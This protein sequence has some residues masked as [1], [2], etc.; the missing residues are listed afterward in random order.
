MAHKSRT[1]AVS[2]SQ[3]IVLTVL[4]PF[5]LPFR[6][7]HHTIGRLFRITLMAAGAMAPIINGSMARAAS[8]EGLGNLG[9]RWSVAQAVSADGTVVVGDSEG[10]S[11]SEAFRWENGSMIGLGLLVPEGMTGLSSATGVS[12]D[13]SVVVGYATTE[14]TDFVGF[15]WEDSMEPLP[16]SARFSSWYDVSA[17]GSVIVGAADTGAEAARWVNGAMEPLGAGNNSHARAVSSDGSVVVGRSRFTPG[18]EAF[19]WENG[20]MIGLD[21]VYGASSLPRDVSADGSVVVGSAVG[22]A[23]RWEDGVME[24]LGNQPSGIFSTATGVSADGSVLVGQGSFDNVR[25]AVIWDADRGMRRIKDVLVNDFGLDLTGWTLSEVYDVSADGNVIVGAGQ[26]PQGNLEG[27]IAR[28][29]VGE[30]FHWASTTSGNYSVASNWTPEG[31]PGETDNAIFDPTGTYTVTIDDD[32]P[33]GINSAKVEAGQVTFEFDGDALGMDTLTV[34]GEGNSA[35]LKLFGTD[36][37]IVTTS[38]ATGGGSSLEGPLAGQVASQNVFVL[39]QGV[40]EVFSDANAIMNL[41]VDDKAVVEGLLEIKE[42]GRLASSRLIIGD[43]G[44][45]GSVKLSSTVVDC[46]ATISAANAVLGDDQNFGIVAGGKGTLEIGANAEAV[47][48][49]LIVGDGGEGQVTVKDGGRLDVLGEMILADNVGAMGQVDVEGNSQVTVGG[50]ITVGS[51]VNAALAFDLD[52][53]L[54]IFDTAQVNAATGLDVGIYGLV[55]IQGRDANANATLVLSGDLFVR[56]DA[57][58]VVL[59]DGGRLE[60]P[61]N[62]HVGIKLG[63]DSQLILVSP[64]AITDRPSAVNLAESSTLNIEIGLP[65]DSGV[66][67]K[68]EVYEGSILNASLIE[69]GTA[70]LS[71]GELIVDTRNTGRHAQVRAQIIDVGANGQ[72]L[73]RNGATV[74]LGNRSS[75]LGAITTPPN[76][77]A[78]K[79]LVLP[80]GF[81]VFAGM[82]EV[83]DALVVREGGYV[84]TGSSPGQG[85]LS[86][87]FILEEGGQWNIEVAGSTA[88][89]EYDQ[90]ILTGDATIGGTVTFEFIDEFAPSQGD[91]FEFLVASGAVDLST[92]QFEVRNLAPGFEFDIMPSAGGIMLMALNDGV[93]L[94]P[95]PGDYNG[96]GTVDAADYVLWRKNPT[97]FGGDAGYTTWRANYGS[98]IGTGSLSNTAVPEPGTLVLASLGLFGVLPFRHPKLL[99]HSFPFL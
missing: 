8:F 77:L 87:N 82:V 86:G 71:N 23:F 43:E 35:G 51:L 3:K 54:N 27:W 49:K 97:A 64:F 55:V 10:P 50:K 53:T 4:N 29:P 5:R 98:T 15:R 9:G 66:E 90:L 18:G 61:D 13:G 70:P 36:E 73:V 34:G 47:F 88:G 62:T 1:N 99:Q 39:P 81:L 38:T 58:G 60:I 14:T 52:S 20:S 91:E 40:L 12:D 45:D 74:L 92:A 83:G 56:D 63:A 72:M 26:S 79:V 84:E 46:P 44:R 19:R 69:V 7:S 48:A 80:G 42:S 16:G 67:A 68:V 59:A 31:V 75:I 21:S 94:A 30:D 96:D 28:L 37:D 78:N 17:D 89:D 2:S 32:A 33:A 24:I 65:S 11:G 25:E 57:S 93:F 76:E 22:G 41:E 85:T 95:I 6:L